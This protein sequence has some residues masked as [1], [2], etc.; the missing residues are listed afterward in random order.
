MNTVSIPNDVL[1]ALPKSSL[2]RRL[3]ENDPTLGK[4]LTAVARS[5]VFG[6]LNDVQTRMSAS[7]RV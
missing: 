2:V 3:Y 6:R 5:K 4:D 1:H 7:K